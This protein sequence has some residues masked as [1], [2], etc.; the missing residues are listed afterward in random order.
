M[1]VGKNKIDLGRSFEA[2]SI[3]AEHHTAGN[4]AHRTFM[5]ASILFTTG[6]QLTENN[7]ETLKWEN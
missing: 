3:T 4:F 1:F 6:P 7:E 2:L 5:G